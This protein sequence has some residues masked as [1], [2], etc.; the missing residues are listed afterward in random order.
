MIRWR[1]RKCGK[2]RPQSWFT[3]RHGYCKECKARLSRYHNERG[4]QA[5]ENTRDWIGYEPR[6]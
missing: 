1:C 3:S 6:Y 5:D 2:K 4:R